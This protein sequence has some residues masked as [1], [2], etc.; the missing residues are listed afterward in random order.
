MT[1]FYLN[2]LFKGCTLK[3]TFQGTE[4]K[5]LTHEFWRGHNSSHNSIHGLEVLLQRI[6]ELLKGTAHMGMFGANLI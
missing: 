5:T 2:Y 3:V 6:S 1:S 4:V